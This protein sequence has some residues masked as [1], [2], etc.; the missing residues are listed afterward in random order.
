MVRHRWQ[1]FV[2]HV[3]H[4]TTAV[5]ELDAEISAH[6]TLEVQR[7]V[8]AGE[9]PDEARRAASRDF[10]NVLLVKEV[11]RDMWG[12]GFVEGCGQD[13]RLAGRVLLKHRLMSM[14]ATLSLALAIA[15]NTTVFSLVSAFIFHTVAIRTPGAAGGHVPDQHLSD[16]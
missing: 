2:R 11:T 15:G 7:R 9:S 4:R 8:D 14:V 5:D 1:W 16:G 3:L 10:G 6:L 12:W 13:L